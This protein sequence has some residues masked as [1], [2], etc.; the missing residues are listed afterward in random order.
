MK[1]E[2]IC[3]RALRRSDSEQLYEWINSRELVLLS[4]SFHPVSEPDHNAWMEAMI[5]RRSDLV[6]FVIEERSTATAIGTCQLHNINWR[7]RHAELQ[8]RIGDA[9]SRRKGLGSEAV[10]LL[11]QFGFSDLNLHRIF[12]HV[13]SSN[14][15]AI[16]AYEKAGF[17]REGILKDAAYIDGQYQDVFLMGKVR[18]NE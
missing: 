2:R 7:H 6:I 10:L 3:L 8:I 18:S 13:F 15:P 9:A 4:S 12:L 11:C 14:I 5:S 17:T 1:T 16:T